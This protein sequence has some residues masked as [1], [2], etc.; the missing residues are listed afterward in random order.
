MAAAYE[1]GTTGIVSALAG[2]S[3]AYG[4]AGAIGTPFLLKRHFSASITTLIFIGGIAFGS[5]GIL[6]ATAL[7]M[8]PGTLSIFVSFCLS[9]SVGGVLLGALA[10]YLE[11]QDITVEKSYN[12]RFSSEKKRQ[13]QVKII[14]ILLLIG[15][16]MFAF[17]KLIA[18]QRSKRFVA[19]GGELNPKPLEAQWHNITISKNSKLHEAAIYGN[20]MSATYLIEMGADVNHKRSDGWTPLH[21]AALNGKKSMV[22][23]LI[24]K[25]ADVN[26]QADNG[27]TP[28]H[29]ALRAGE[30]KT[31]KF[32]V[33]NGADSCLMNAHGR[34]PFDI[35][36]TGS[37]AEK[38][39]LHGCLNNQSNMESYQN[40]EEIPVYQE[41]KNSDFSQ[42]IRNMEPGERTV[43][44]DSM[45][46][47]PVSL[48]ALIDK[49]EDNMDGSFSVSSMVSNGVSI[50]IFNMNKDD[51]YGL[52][53]GQLVRIKGRIRNIFFEHLTVS[54]H[55]QNIAILERM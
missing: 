6:G 39:G 30:I 21:L 25:G 27:D 33:E 45:K 22:K 8:L 12:Q 7:L 37:I 38:I 46:G 2:Y 24:S 32:L 20:T 42:E 35:A 53:H 52:S 34:R 18:L 17:P 14:S 31:A 44:L 19:S 55:M 15:L 47:K 23:I 36:Q 49:I 41:I 28:L 9:G 16:F 51:V 48:L 50:H 26:M 4:I 13:H 40:F 3:L 29:M 11:E 54:I 1:G 5:G 43:F 10:G